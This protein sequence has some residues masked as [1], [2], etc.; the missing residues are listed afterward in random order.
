MYIVC[1]HEREHKVLLAKCPDREQ[2]EAWKRGVVL[3]DGYK[4]QPVEVR[5]EESKGKGARVRVIMKEGA[6]DRFAKHA[7]S[8]HCLLSEFCVY[9]LVLCV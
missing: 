6:S 7:S 8:W 9:G 4:T 1:S 2:V 5:C 3:E